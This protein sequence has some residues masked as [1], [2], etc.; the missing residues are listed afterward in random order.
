MYADNPGGRQVVS[1][2]SK[3]RSIRSLSDNH[4]ELEDLFSDIFGAFPPLQIFATGEFF[5][6]RSV[7]NKGFVKVN[8]ALFV[9]G[10]SSI[11]SRGRQSVGFLVI[12]LVPAARM[13]VRPPDLRKS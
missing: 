12:A 9:D 5:F 8:M 6:G 1:P 13:M 10:T 2:H 4:F 7:W 11:L 3:P